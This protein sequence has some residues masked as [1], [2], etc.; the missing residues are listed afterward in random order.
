MRRKLRRGRSNEETHERLR[1]TH[2]RRDSTAGR[3]GARRKHST[4]INC[5]VSLSVLYMSHGT[6]SLIG[7]NVA[8]GAGFALGNSGKRRDC[9]SDSGDC[10]LEDHDYCVCNDRA[11]EAR[12]ERTR[13]E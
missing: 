9:E 2:C 4:I 8:V 10:E 7:S 11:A 13:R 6:D 1:R 3:R 12:E 5:F